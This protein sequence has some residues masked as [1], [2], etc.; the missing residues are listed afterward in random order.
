MSQR[1]GYGAKGLRDPRESHAQSF[2][3][4]PKWRGEGP[5]LGRG[6]EGPQVP[7]D[8]RRRRRRLLE[9][10]GPHWLRRLSFAVSFSNWVFV[11]RSLGAFQAEKTEEK[12]EEKAEARSEATE[13][14]SGKALP[15]P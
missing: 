13:G 4:L 3:A 14:N 12:A 11:F 5:V 6:L 1:R 8:G 7:A 9:S 2:R 10:G 15:L